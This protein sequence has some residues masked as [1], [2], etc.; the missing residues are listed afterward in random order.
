VK[1][2]TRLTRL[3]IAFGA[4][5]VLLTAAAPA[6]PPTTADPD[7]VMVLGYPRAPVTV[8]EYASVGCPHCAHWAKTVYPAFKAK[9]I[10]TGRVK[11][12]FHEMLTGDG[13]LA[14][15]GFLLARCAGPSNYFQV[16]DQVFDKQN[17]IVAQGAPALM[18]IG[19][20]A[21]VSEDAFKACMSDTAALKALAARTEADATAHHVRGTPTFFIGNVRLAGAETLPSFDAAIA[22]ARRH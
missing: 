17:E 22:R 9:Y 10:D 18:A 6:S 16:V 3:A 14:A 15:A 7:G 5:G 13:P 20:A 1:Q 4:I 2:M 19:E 21:G 8:T 11:F 12:A